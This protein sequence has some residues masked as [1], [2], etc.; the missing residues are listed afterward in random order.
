[1]EI[2]VKNGHDASTKGVQDLL[3]HD[4]QFILL[5]IKFIIDRLICDGK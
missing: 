2:D 3:L 5:N 1:M 4:M